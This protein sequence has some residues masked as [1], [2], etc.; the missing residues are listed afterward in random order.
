MID[1]RRESGR[2]TFCDRKNYLQKSN[3]KDNGEF[4]V[5]VSLQA[6]HGRESQGLPI[7]SLSAAANS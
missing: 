5:S 3:D 6:A 4:C 2:F 7:P 1:I